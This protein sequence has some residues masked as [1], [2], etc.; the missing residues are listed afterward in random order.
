[1]FSAGIR[2]PLPYIAFEYSDRGAGHFASA[3]VGSARRSKS[4]N[5]DMPGQQE[6]IGELVLR[7][8]LGLHARPA[9]LFVQTAS[10]FSADIEVT[11]GGQSGDGKSI[12]G[13][14]TLAA[15]EGAALSVAARG[16]DAAAALEALADLVKDGFGEK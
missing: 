5:K 2:L 15:G 6:A 14:L 10:R 16:H 13:L 11:K 12:L 1:M 8:K 7:N 9:A 3:A 4:V